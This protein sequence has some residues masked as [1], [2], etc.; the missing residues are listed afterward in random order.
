MLVNGV[1][2]ICPVVDG[3]NITP[4]E[5][6]VGGSV[7]VNAAAHDSDAAPSALSL[8]VDGLERHAEQR[9]GS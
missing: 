6:V 8:P 9:H 7:V 1:L 5:L 2:N 3:L 4:N